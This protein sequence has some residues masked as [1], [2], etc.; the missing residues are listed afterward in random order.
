MLPWGR[1]D[2]AFG[3]QANLARWHAAFPKAEVVRLEQ[4]GHDIREDAPQAIIE[5]IVRV[6]GRAWRPAG[7]GHDPRSRR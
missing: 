1:R 4:A 6:H 5:A 2:P 3:S 7:A